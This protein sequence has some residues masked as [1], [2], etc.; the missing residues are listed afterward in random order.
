MRVIK[1]A[2]RNVVLPLPDYKEY[3]PTDR[4]YYKMRLKWREAEVW[5]NNLSTKSILNADDVC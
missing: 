1:A 2:Y 5:G 3:S 4:T